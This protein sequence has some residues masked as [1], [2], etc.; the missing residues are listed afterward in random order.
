MSKFRPGYSN[1]FDGLTVD[2]GWSAGYLGNDEY[3]P[4][5]G[6]DF[7]VREY[8]STGRPQTSSIE[9][10]FTLAAGAGAIRIPAAAALVEGSS[11][12]MKIIP[13]A[14]E[15]YA[16]IVHGTITPL[17]NVRAYSSALNTDNASDLQAAADVQNEIHAFDSVV[18]G[19][20][21]N[22]VIISFDPTNTTSEV[23]GGKIFIRKKT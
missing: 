5:L 16:F 20:G 22:Y 21:L 6:T 19:N 11:Y 23:F 14:Y 13:R 8:A 18:P 15:A 9:G 17:Y 12:A 1:F 7:N 10:Q 4:L 2:D 3:I